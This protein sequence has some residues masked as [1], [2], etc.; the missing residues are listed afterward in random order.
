MVAADLANLDQGRPGKVLIKTFKI[1][2]AA[3]KLK[4]GRDTVIRASPIGDLKPVTQDKPAPPCC[5]TG[6]AGSS[7]LWEDRRLSRPYRRTPREGKQPARRP[8]I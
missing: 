4:V 8:S 3:K 7:G 6:D 1:K 5:V 2:K